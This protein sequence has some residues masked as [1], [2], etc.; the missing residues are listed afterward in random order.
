MSPNDNN[1]ATALELIGLA[2]Q[3]GT[4][5]AFYCDH[6][7][8]ANDGRWICLWRVADGVAYNLQGEIAALP[9]QFQ[10]SREAFR[11]VWAEAGRLRDMDQALEFVL[12]WLVDRAEVDDLTFASRHIQRAGI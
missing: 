5:L 1:A 2:W 9:Q 8:F 10:E 4:D 7:A 12:A 6:S 3:R 11:G